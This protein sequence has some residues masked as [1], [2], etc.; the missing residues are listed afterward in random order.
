MS[1]DLECPYCKEGLEAPEECEATEILHEA[2][3][4][5]CGK[6]FGFYTD[7]SPTY[8]ESKI[9][10]WNGEAH[11]WEPVKVQSDRFFT[12]RERC[13]YCDERR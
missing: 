1:K 9:P 13:A 10:C 8:R 5:H 11:K 6:F 3:C 2:E 7:W 4:P 12:G